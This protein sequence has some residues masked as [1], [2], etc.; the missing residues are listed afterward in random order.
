[1]DA[2]L[3]RVLIGGASMRPTLEVG[4]VVLVRPTRRVRAGDV[5][6]HESHGTPICH[7]AVLVIPWWGRGRVVHQGDAPGARP[8]LVDGAT[9]LGRVVA[10]E[11]V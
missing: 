10:V 6:V 11:R 5:I 7:R 9:V 1:M 4:D 2:A 3:R 8:A